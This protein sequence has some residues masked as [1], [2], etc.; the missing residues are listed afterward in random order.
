MASHKYNRN[1]GLMLSCPCG[2]ILTPM[3][4]K[5][6]LHTKNNLKEHSPWSHLTAQ[7]PQ[8][9]SI[10]EAPKKVQSQWHW[11]ATLHGKAFLWAIQLKQNNMAPKNIHYLFVMSP[12]HLK[13]P[14]H[15]ELKRLQYIFTLLFPTI[16][17][18][19]CFNFSFFLVTILR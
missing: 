1:H 16:L 10:V 5:A 14:L 12:F 18:F 9:I 7:L 19:L 17:W 6:I 13:T 11:A 3:F 8:Q 4:V 2:A 15:T